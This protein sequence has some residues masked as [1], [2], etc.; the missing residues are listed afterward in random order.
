MPAGST[1]AFTPNAGTPQRATGSFGIRA[2]SQVGEVRD[3]PSSPVSTFSHVRTLVRRARRTSNIRSESG[4]L[5]RERPGVRAR[6]QM[7][8]RRVQR[9][10]SPSERSTRVI[11]REVQHHADGH[12]EVVRSDEKGF[13]FITPDEGSRD[14]FV[15][16][17]G[18]NADGYRSLPRARASL[19]GGA[20]RQG[21]EGGRRLEALGGDR[22]ARAASPNACEGPRAAGPSSSQ[23]SATAASS[24]RIGRPSSA[25]CCRPPAIE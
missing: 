5:P 13:G 3:G 17:T 14:L 6:H 7:C 9:A 18:I 15:L 8:R 24:G 19:R 11:R 16:H 22:R 20:G 10:S 12:R 21:A 25:H 2:L 4:T 23:W 1:T